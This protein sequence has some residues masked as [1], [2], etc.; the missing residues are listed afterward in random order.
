[1]PWEGRAFH[2]NPHAGDSGET[3]PEVAT[4]LEAWRLGIG[5]YTDFV[6]ALAT[7]RLLIPLVAHAGDEFDPSHPVMEDKVQELS[8]VTVAGPNGEKVI[9]T[10]TSVAAM[11]AWNSDARPIPIEAQR[12]ALAAAS[13]QTDRIVLNPGTDS[14]VIRRP[15][16]WAMAK[17]ETYIACWE[18]VNFVTAAQSLLAGIS[19]L[20]GVRVAPADLRATG[21]GPDVALVLELPEGLTDDEVRT[22]LT[23][24]HGRVSTSDTFR[25]AVDALT[26]SI[27]K[28]AATERSG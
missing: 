22:A 28:V 20:A 26:I 23:E 2:D 27:V 10:F 11:S 17:G 3:P 9:P 5:A 7:S 4:R 19:N 6:A 24:V 15:A 12:V 13:E 21:E 25:D 14:I 18:S 8:V 16:L 1:V